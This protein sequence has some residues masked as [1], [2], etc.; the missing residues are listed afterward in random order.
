MNSFELTSGP[1]QIEILRYS[2]FGFQSSFNPS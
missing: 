2:V 1:A